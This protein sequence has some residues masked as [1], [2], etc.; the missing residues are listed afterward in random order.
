MKRILPVL[1]FVLALIPAIAHAELRVD[2][3]R[4]TIEPMPIAISPFIRESGAD[5][6]LASEMP[7]V[8]SNNLAGSG[9]FKPVNPAAFVQDA[10]SIQRDGVRF[11][12]WRATNTQA[13]VTGTVTSQ[14]DGKA[15]VEFRLWDVYGQKQLIG[16]AY[17]TTQQNWRRIAHIISDEIY[18]NL[19]G[20]NGYFD[21]RIVYVS[22]SGPATKRVKRLAIMDQDGA[23]HKYLTDGGSLVLTP[24][25][26]PTRQQR[27]LHVV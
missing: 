21:S 1:L 26:S 19:T 6:N 12:E 8:I 3:T 15:R 22:E 17:T 13:L 18:K 2:V 7:K 20:E 25:F 16:M 9:L 27:R 24:R 14:P 11:A 10:A 5:A 23:N 4:G